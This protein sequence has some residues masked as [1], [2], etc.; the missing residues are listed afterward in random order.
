MFYSIKYASPERLAGMHFDTFYNHHIQKVVRTTWWA[1]LLYHNKRHTHV[2]QNLENLSLDS[3][4]VWERRKLLS[5][6]CATQSHGQHKIFPKFGEFQQRFWQCKTLNFSWNSIE[7]EFECKRIRV[8]I[9]FQWHRR[10]R[11]RS[12]ENISSSINIHQR[13]RRDCVFS[14]MVLNLYSDLLLKR[15]LKGNTEGTKVNRCLGIHYT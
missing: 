7:N 14:P 11:I 6:Y 1:R 3:E 8:I 9:N 5:A 4:M 13:V 12:D 10:A 15:V 2:K